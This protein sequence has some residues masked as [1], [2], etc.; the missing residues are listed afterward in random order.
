MLKAHLL[1][2]EG[3]KPFNRLRINWLGIARG[4]ENILKVLQRHLGFAISIDNVPQLLQRSKDE[5]RINHERKELPDRDLLT[6][7]QVKHQKQNAGAQRINRGSLNEAQAAQI[8]HFLE[9]QFEN[10]FRDPVEPPYFL[11]GKPQALHQFNV[12]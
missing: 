3:H 4:V 1:E 2:L 12:A 5:K 7:D 6:E 10:L 8:F 11:V 9:F